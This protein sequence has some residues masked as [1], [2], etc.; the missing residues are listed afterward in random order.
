MSTKKQTTKRHVFSE[1]EL[2]QLKKYLEIQTIRK[3]II[4]MFDG[5]CCSSCSL[6]AQKENFSDFISEWHKDL[7]RSVENTER[8]IREGKA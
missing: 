7:Q 6:Y 3:E 1:T 2:Q 5:Y 8:M 4:G